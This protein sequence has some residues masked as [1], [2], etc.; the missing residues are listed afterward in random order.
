MRSLVPA[1]ASLLVAVV[2]L[3]VAAQSAG[4]GSADA[5][6]WV[7]PRSGVYHCP[8][9]PPYGT[10]ARGSYMSESDAR[11]KR[12]RP[13]GGREC[14]SAAV[15]QQQGIMTLLGERAERPAA[16]FAILR[17]PA[18]PQ[19]PTGAL[20]HCLV[21][22]ISDGDGVE[23]QSQGTIRLIGVDAPERDQEPFGTAAHAALLSLAPVG[24]ELQLESD[25][26]LRDRYNRRLAYLWSDSLMINWMMVR[27]GWSVAFPYGSTSRY[28]TS[29]AAAEARAR[30]ERRGLWDVGGFDCLPSER[31]ERRC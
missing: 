22:R 15:P 10:T 20:E 17:D 28:R 1:L 29:F 25:V 12:Y 31:R 27:L 18:A 21:V 26:E 9:T 30:A 5:R 13:A 16:F 4:E 2:A 8:G 24:T 11:A 19:Y 7:N 3:P 6:V 23:C 14:A